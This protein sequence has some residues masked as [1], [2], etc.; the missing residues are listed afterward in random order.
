MSITRNLPLAKDALAVECRLKDFALKQY[1]FYVKR[2]F[3]LM[4]ACY[5]S[6]GATKCL[7][8]I[9]LLGFHKI[10]FSSI[11]KWGQCMSKM[12]VIAANL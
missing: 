12:I 1:A 10:Q 3:L 5:I 9:L 7:S 6:Q 4:S 8:I 11:F 2:K